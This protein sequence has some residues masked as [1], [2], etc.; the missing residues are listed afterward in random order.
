MS[1]ISFFDLRD[2]ILYSITKNDLRDVVR[3]CN[4]SNRHFL[5]CTNSLNDKKDSNFLGLRV[6]YIVVL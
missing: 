5:I 6:H 1:D 3:L 2:I 4:T